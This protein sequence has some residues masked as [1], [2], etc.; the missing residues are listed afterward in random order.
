M[1][2]MT[3]NVLNGRK[4]QLQTKKQQH[5]L[6]IENTCINVYIAPPKN[7]P[8]QYGNMPMF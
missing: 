3:L 2:E 4:S 8:K 6:N 1:A 5:N 7:G